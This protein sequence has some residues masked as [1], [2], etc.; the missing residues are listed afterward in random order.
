MAASTAAPNYAAIKEQQ[1]QTWASG[2]YAIIGTM[3][4]YMAET[5]CEAMDLHAGWR[6]L[7]VA[8]G[9]GNAALAAAR[10]MCDVVCTDYVPSLL[11]RGRERA[12]AERLEIAFEVADAENL[13]YPDASFDAITSVVGVMFAP[14]QERA[15]AELL[16]VCKPGGMIGLANWTPDGCIGELLRIVGKYAPPPAGVKPSVLWGTQERLRQL[17]G[18]GVASLGVHQRSFALRAR[19]AEECVALF[20]AW[21]GPVNRAFA[22][23]D[24]AGQ[25]ALAGEMRDL[26][27]RYN[28]ATDGTIMAPA[29]YLE[30]VATKQ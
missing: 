11:E 12:A 6:V 18:D 26:L 3:I 2:D 20:R 30:V 13:P 23:Q 21:Y 25:E 19:S 9:S 7:D 16:R 28:R 8:G 24:T 5:L 15:A 29:D 14:D 1:Q 10:R 17:F 22:G 27:D 4:S